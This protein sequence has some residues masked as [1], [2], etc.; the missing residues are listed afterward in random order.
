MKSTYYINEYIYYGTKK[1]NLSWMIIESQFDFDLIL[2]Q[3]SP[4]FR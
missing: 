1:Y 4:V 3:N 2:N